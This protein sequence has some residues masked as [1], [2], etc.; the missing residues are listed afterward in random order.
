MNTMRRYYKTLI[1]HSAT[2]LLVLNSDDQVEL[3]NEVACRYAGISP[4]STN[5][6][7]LQVKNPEFYE[8][9]CATATG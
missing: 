8:A 4:D 5:P 9:L 6:N 1:Q 7:I 2:G 3:I